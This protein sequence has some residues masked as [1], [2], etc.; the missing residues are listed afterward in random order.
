MD[1][2]IAGRHVQVTEAM[3]S[4]IWQQV[5]KLPPFADKVQYLSV[6]LAVDAG[7]QLAEILAKSHRADF[8]AQASSHDMYES[9][10]Q[11]FQ[12]LARQL[13]RQHDKLV[14]SRFPKIEPAAD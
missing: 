6:T 14:N 12:K 9:I 2:Q 8:V 11:A 4:H 3:E 5:E 13:K 10:D 7:S 1:V